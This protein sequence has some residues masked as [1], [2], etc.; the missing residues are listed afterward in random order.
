[1]LVLSSPSGAGKSTLTRDLLS[2]TALDLTLSISVTTRPRRSSEVRR[3]PL[4]F[5]HQGR[6]RDGC[7]IA[8]SCSNGRRCTAITTARRASRS[9]AVLR[10]G[11]DVL[12]DIDW[13]GAQQVREQGAADVVTMFI[14]PPSMDELKRAAGTP[15]RG[16]ARRHRQ[17]ARERAPRNPA[18]AEYDYVMVNEDI[19]RA[20]HEVQAILIAERMKRTRSEAGIE[21]FVDELLRRIGRRLYGRGFSASTAR[22]PARQT[23]RRRSLRR[24]RSP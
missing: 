20:L 17:A 22:W 9:R 5:H 24:A 11:R 15:R 13:Q 21:R 8:T 2:D 1:M 19:Q 16:R 7:A 12:F 10:A 4:P 6:I 14:L 23:R 18:L 3:H